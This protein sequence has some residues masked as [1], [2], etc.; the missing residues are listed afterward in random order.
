MVGL[1]LMVVGCGGATTAAMDMSTPLDLTLWG[2]FSCSMA[3]T[4]Y[5][6]SGCPSEVTIEG[7]CNSD[8]G[9]QVSVTRQDCG[10][11]TLIGLSRGADSY[12]VSVYDSSTGTLVAVLS[13]SLSGTLDCGAGPPNL[14]IGPC[15]NA[16]VICS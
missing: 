7:Q 8:M 11:F 9:G 6:P 1:A 10:M 16:V 4:N 5:C 13:Q 3:I 12:S 15:S 2:E 14:A